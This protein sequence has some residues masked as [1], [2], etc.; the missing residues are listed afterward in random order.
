MQD[1]S[2]FK[3]PPHSEEA[4]QSVLGGLLLDE[5]AWDRVADLIGA[6]SFYQHAHKVIFEAV[7]Q[8]VDANR[9]PD[10]VTLAENLERQGRL[11]E[12]GGTAYLASLANNTPTAANIAHYAQ[13]VR[14]RALLRS[15]ITAATEI[16][17]D[18]FNPGARSVSDILDNA[19]QRIFSIADESSQRREGF[20]PLRE[21]MLEGMNRL[22]ELYHQN[23]PLTGLPT[24]F[25]DLD[26]RTSGLQ[27]SDLI[28][29]AGR[30]SMGK[31]SFV[32]NMAES[33]ITQD[34]PAPVALFSL[35]M[36]REQLTMRLLA[37][38]A[39][40]D[41]HKMRN[42]NLADDDWP[43]LTQAVGELA[44]AP[45][46]IDDTPG[47]GPIEIRARCR[48]LKREHGLGL[49]IV[50]YLQLMQTPGEA[51]SRAVAISD[52]SR[53]LKA[54]ARELDVPVIALSQLN[55]SLEQRSDKRPMMSDLRESG[56]IEQDADIIMFIYRDEVYQPDN[57]E[58]QGLAELIVAKQRNGP[59]GTV[60]LTFLDEYTRF[61]NY[62]GPE[63]ASEY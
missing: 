41:A 7:G 11:E 44:E 60:R 14:E 12:V 62:A 32:M 45:L 31:T 36:P 39:R 33:V 26:D 49:V 56:A 50:D 43:R 15:L 52:I 1:P 57:P 16:S 21:L 53:S 37:S 30:P 38:R 61:E 48:R 55:R 29:I 5:S 42:G 28:I 63:L 58:V 40:I 34:Q 27:A 3:V 9:P 8:L 59:T 17:E 22:D 4:E 51:E 19:E 47:L 35:E 18:A 54:L 23:D 10:L 2:A 6:G 13:V 24:G 20:S 25:A 46:Y